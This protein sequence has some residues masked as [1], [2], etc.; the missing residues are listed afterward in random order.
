MPTPAH[1]SAPAPGPSQPPARLGASQVFVTALGLGTAALAGPYGVPGAERAAPEADEARRTLEIALDRGVRFIDT[2]PAY[3]Q[4]EAV[5]G[6]VCEGEACVIATKLEIP[7]RG[8]SSLAPA[9]AES[10]TRASVERS[11]ARLRRSHIDLLQIH[12]AEVRTFQ[13]GRLPVV[14]DALRGEGLVRACGATVYGPDN[15]MAALACEALDAVQ[16]ASSALDR[17][18]ERLLAPIAAERG[19]TLIARS[20]LL[21]G[22][23][24][25][26]GRSLNGPLAP[27]REA[28]DGFRRAIGASWDELP[29]AAV[30]FVLARPGIA[31]A[32]LGP[33]DSSELTQLL[34]GAKRFATRAAQVDG[35]WDACLPPQLL[36]PSQWPRA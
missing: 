11:L 28:A 20:L 21:R 2:A 15:A 6:E 22:V 19:R 23:L 24:S 16:V 8:W 25:P 36:D 34:D 12:N 32:L 7:E 35:D 26:A 17:R 1:Q 4:L 10:F 5:V 9:E 30:A 29:G 18:A 27:L 14:L 31:S 13:Q 33:R 3:G